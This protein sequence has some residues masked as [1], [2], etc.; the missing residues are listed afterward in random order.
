[1]DTV[2]YWR[3]DQINDTGTTTGDVWSFTSYPPPRINKVRNYPYPSTV[4]V[5]FTH[6]MSNTSVLRDTSTYRLNNGAYVTNVEVL[7]EERIRLTTENLFGFKEFTLSVET[8]TEELESTDGYAFD[9]TNT[10]TIELSGESEGIYAL[11]AANG[12]IKSGQ[13]AVKVYSDANYFYVMTES[14]IDVVDKNSLFNKGFV[15]QQSGFNTIF[16][17]G[18]D[19][20]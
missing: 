3:I 11:S 10:A 19:E 8:G 2:Y 15:L 13:K 14:G 20:D 17:G 1:M 16:I 5:Q 7:D 6:S 4:E 12:R 9:K 18:N